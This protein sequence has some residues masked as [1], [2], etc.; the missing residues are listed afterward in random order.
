MAGGEIGM[1]TSAINKGAEATSGSRQHAEGLGHE[2]ERQ[3]LAGIRM[4]REGG[5]DDRER[6]GDDGKGNTE[7]MQHIAHE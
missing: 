3:A 6:P 2:I 1:G 5:D 7:Q 4:V